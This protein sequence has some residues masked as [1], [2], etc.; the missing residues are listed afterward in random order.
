MRDDWILSLYN[1]TYL[2]FL[3]KSFLII[4][5]DYKKALDKY[6]SALKELNKAHIMELR[7]L[8]PGHRERLLIFKLVGYVIRMV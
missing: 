2:S 8:K 3:F 5:E 4:D 6:L 7:N 1:K